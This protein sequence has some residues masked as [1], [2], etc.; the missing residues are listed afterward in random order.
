MAPA[1]LRRLAAV[2]ALAAPLA[3]AAAELG[4]LFHSPA[5]RE[6]LDRAR[7]GLP[8]GVANAAPQGPAA[9]TGYV[10]RSDG[11][12][13]LWIDGT[14]VPVAGRR[15]PGLFDPRKVEGTAPG[16]VVPSREPAPPSPA[17]PKPG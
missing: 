10:E 6:R 9:V 5:E 14:P 15:A 13:T 11:R 3:A 12:N 16:L 17:S 8:V 2:L 4:T 7:R 1:R